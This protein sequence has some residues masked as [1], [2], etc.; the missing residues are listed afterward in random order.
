MLPYGQT[1]PARYP[2]VAVW[3]LIAACVL[4]FLHQT[5]LP[6]RVLEVFLFHY[7]LVPARFFGPLAAVAPGDPM[8]FLTNMFLH[9]GWLHLILNMWTLWVFG[10]AVEDRLGSLR[11]L[12]FYLVC[13][14]AASFAHA[15]ANPDSVI[16]ALGASGAIAGI[17]GCYAR[18]FPHA[19]LVMMVP[20]LFIPL[21][22]EVRAIVFAAIWFAMQAIPGIL[23]FGQQTDSGGIAWWAHIGGFV[24]GWLLAPLVHRP[25]RGYRRYYRDE[26][27]A[28]FRP[29]G[30]RIGGRG[31]WG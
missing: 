6:P 16:P 31:P 7:A 18:F 23:E 29:D 17:I 19:R 2:A 24:A 3:T 10:P 15:L 4:A 12:G 27:I 26:G 30:R 14:L 5:S 1:I 22:F 11:F 9:G 8:V 20:V 28:G 21:F 25:R 13:G